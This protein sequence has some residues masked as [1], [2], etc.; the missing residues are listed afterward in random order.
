[1]SLPN[2]QTII[3]KHS[4]LPSIHMLIKNNNIS[5]KNINNNIH[6]KNNILS[7]TFIQSKDNLILKLIMKWKRKIHFP[8]YIQNN[9]TI[10]YNNK[11]YYPKIFLTKNEYYNTLKICFMK[12]YKL[13][14]TSYWKNIIKR[15]NKINIYITHSG[16]I[17]FK[18]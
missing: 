3:Q 13:L 18:Y 1:M 10:Y 12:I 9:Q 7:W 6:D 5:S 4:K 8:I 16:F 11:K 14:K 2:L 15:K 17:I